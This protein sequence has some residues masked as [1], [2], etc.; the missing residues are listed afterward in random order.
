MSLQEVIG[1]IQRWDEEGL[2]TC[3]A[4]LFKVEGSSPRPPGSR[5]A[6][7]ERGDMAGY[8]SLGCVEGDVREHIRQI[9][10]GGPPRTIH[11]GVADEQALAVGLSCGGQIDVFL[12][13]HDPATP[14]WQALCRRAFQEPALLLTRISPP[15]EGRQL[16][17]EAGGAKHGTL[18]S[19]DLDN[20]VLE[21]AGRIST[22]SGVD[23]VE[24][25]DVLCLAE[26]LSPPLRLAIVGATPVAAS[27][28]KLASAMGIEVTVVDPRRDFAN[29]LL[30]PSARRIIL[31]WP[32]EGLAEAGVGPDWF[33]AVLSHDPKLDLPALE[34][35][36]RAGCRYIGLLGGRKTQAQRKEALLEKGFTPVDLARLRGPI[37]LK[38]GA[39]TPDEIAVCVLAEIIQVSRATL[40]LP[41]T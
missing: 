38:L 23:L 40:P 25:D 36:L 31:K 16:F 22:R 30:F 26:V 8:I 9:L 6:V 35:A 24:V 5:L 15:G 18:G 7:N 11:Y 33:T 19:P 17:A 28:C 21:A 39:V 34:S 37:G 4:L 13:R 29:P 14:A 1:P 10:A 27:L 3:V 32:A 2:K 41:V 12:V 20:R